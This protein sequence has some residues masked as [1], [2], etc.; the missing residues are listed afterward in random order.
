MKAF[1]RPIS[2]FHCS[3]LATL[4][5]AGSGVGT[6]LAGP[7]AGERT[8]F[9]N[10]VR[11]LPAALK[12]TLHPMS[13]AHLSETVSF[14]IPLALRNPDELAARVNRG[15]IIS[16]E[17]LRAKYL[18]LP[19][20]YDGV[21]AWLKG[22]GFAV[23]EI[24]DTRL[25]VFARGTVAQV[26][27]SF[28]VTAGLVTAKGV[29]RAVVQTA[30]S[31]PAAVARPALGVSGLSYRRPHS[32]LVQPTGTSP[33]AVR[34]GGYFVGDI[35]TAYSGKSLSVNGTTL[36]GAGQTIGI[37]AYVTVKSTDLS[38]F[39]SANGIT[40]AS[41]TTVT[42][43]NVNN[44]TL[45]TDTGDVQENALDVEWASSVA[46]GANIVDYA[47]NYDTNDAPERIYAR[48]LSDAMA[49]GSTLHTFSSSYGP[50]EVDLTSTELTAYNNYFMM[51]T[52]AGLTYIN[53][54]GDYGSSNSAGTNPAP[55][56][57]GDCPYATGV[58]G[59][60]LQVT[61]T[62]SDTRSTETGWSGSAG[63]YS[64]Y[65]AVPA[66]QGNT[67]VSNPNAKRMIPDLA[68]AADPNTGAYY[69]YN[70]K[71]SE[72]GGTSWAAPTFAGFFAMIQQG[73]ALNTPARAPVGFLNPRLYPLVGTTNFFDVTSG[74]NGSYSAATGYDLVTG[75][76][77]P[78]VS[79]L[80]ATLLGPTITSFTPTTGPAGTTVT[81]T[82]TNFYANGTAYPVAVSFGRTA[83]T[84]VT[85]LSATQLTAVVPVGA[86]TG[87]VVV[88]SFGDPATSGSNFTVLAPDLTVTSAHTGNFTQAD[89]GDTY[90]LTVANAGTAATS[91]TV[92]VTDTLP[93]GLTA[94]AL[95]GTGWTVAANNLSATRSDALAAGGSYPALTLTVNVSSTAAS[96]VTNNV[97]VSGG[98]ESNTANDTGTD[99]TTINALTPSQSWRYQY[100][101]TT[102]NSGNAADTANPSGD[103][104][105]NLVKYALGLDPRTP[106]VNPVTADTSTGYL[107]L[108][109]PR[110][111]NATDITYSVQVTSDL[112]N[113]ASWTTNGTTT[114]Q[115]SST[116]LQVQ[117][118]TPVSGT[119]KRFIRLQISR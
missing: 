114:T 17:E 75:V 115:S 7:A 56:A 84:N 118:N 27:Q 39:W 2:A 24:G 26:Q 30:P 99:A 67:T 100:F 61:S 37:E 63:G 96:S 28:Q 10:S 58:G 108:T 54:T 98:G 18:P 112:T 53:A 70:A 6:V 110:N 51:M 116:T 73:R 59:T 77:V 47:T 86:A 68:L 4:A 23:D 8:T 60:S 9:T 34:S 25:A 22:E 113:P 105:V 79:N 1:R 76:G 85:L 89:T 46:P 5:L 111:A 41:G 107:R 104:L 20:D 29:E 88:T 13:A 40:R 82:G 35:V 97:V 21:A 38:K 66:Y 19:A 91:G 92:T 101:G 43:L 11:E 119:A 62:T 57:Y 33:D 94:T 95:S 90:T 16:G 36:N 117:D 106:E 12:S 87:A 72:V 44:A 31:L 65:F 64:N 80:L 42:T 102:A 109:V 32:R 14:N 71:V 78:T 93:G 48:A 83:A 69:V 55:E 15:E 50:D 3:L 49:S 103:G 74:S 81:I 52:A 45:A